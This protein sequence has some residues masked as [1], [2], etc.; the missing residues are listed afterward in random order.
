MKPNIKKLISVLLLFVMLPCFVLPSAAMTPS[1]PTNIVGGKSYG[2]KISTESGVVIENQTVTYNISTFPTFD[3]KAMVVEEYTGSV[4]TE[5]TLYNP[6]DSKIDVKLYSPF[7]H[8]GKHYFNSDPE[9]SK[10]SVSVEGAIG[11]VALRHSYNNYNDPHEISTSIQD[12]YIESEFVSPDLPVTKY[13]FKQT[14]IEE[15]EAYLA[16]DFDRILLGRNCFCFNV[17]VEKKSQN[18]NTYRISMPAVE[19]GETFDIFV[20]GDPLTTPPVLNVYQDKPWYGTVTAEGNIELIGQESMTLLDYLLTFRDPSLE[21]S[22]VDW[23]NMAIM[24]IEPILIRH[25][26][27]YYMGYLQDRLINDVNSIY[28]CDLSILPGERAT[29]RITAPIYPEI[30]TNYDPPTFFYQYDLYTDNAQLFSGN[31]T[32]NINTPYSIIPNENYIFEKTD[33]GYS[34]T[35]PAS[36]SF[37][38]GTG[39]ISGGVFFTLCEV[40]EPRNISES[41]WSNLLGVLIV[42][43]IILL[44][45]I[46]VGIAIQALGWCIDQLFNI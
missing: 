36:E 31:I 43:F 6:T 45:V 27:Y 20:I 18:K 11:N 34:L 2:G 25:Y 22:D 17:E 26:G 33:E 46:I 14:G 42:V 23:Y 10:H 1:P 3:S 40:E 39:Y 21:I 4:T 5:Y 28:I 41:V 24:D 19:N 12:E 30:E 35:M 13:T 44:P 16:F 15:E 9:I 32:V 29:V 7:S 8:N 37:D 38:D